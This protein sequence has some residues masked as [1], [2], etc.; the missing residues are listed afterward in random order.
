M[1]LNRAVAG[2]AMASA[3]VMTAGGATALPTTDW[4]R[5][6]TVWGSSYDQLSTVMDDHG[7]VFAS[8]LGRTDHDVYISVRKTK[9]GWSSPTRIVTD[10]PLV[11]IATG[12][13][14]AWVM[15]VDPNWVT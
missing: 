4:G 14:G 2:V 11:R 5:V 3:M 9:G 6:V 10:S 7:T 8:W 15:W 12:G 1:R 13:K